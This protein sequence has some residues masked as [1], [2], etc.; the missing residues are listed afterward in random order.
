MFRKIS[1][2]LLFFAIVSCGKSPNYSN[3]ESILNAWG[4]AI[5]NK[6]YSVYKGT[7]IFPLSDVQFAEEYRDYYPSSFM[8]VDEVRDTYE[9]SSGNK[10]DTITVTGSGEIIN[11][12][13]QL[14]E[15]ITAKIDLEKRI[16]ENWKIKHHIFI[17]KK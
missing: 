15:S 4:S 11:R 7:E 17:W 16:G 9:D 10:I 6:N 1:I 12:N 5:K 14:S 8:V 3:E 13:S 2:F